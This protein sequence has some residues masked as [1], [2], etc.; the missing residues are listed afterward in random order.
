MQAFNLYWSILTLWDVSTSYTT[1]AQSIDDLQYIIAKI[2]NIKQI[3][4]FYY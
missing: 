1:V 2:E 4:F 3:S